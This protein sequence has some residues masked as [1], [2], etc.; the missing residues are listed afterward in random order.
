[1]AL[2]PARIVFFCYNLF[3]V[4]LSYGFLLHMQAAILAFCF[5]LLVGRLGP[6]LVA[7][8]AQAARL[9]SLVL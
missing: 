6:I 9:L 1:M 7:F 8:V 4:A 2:F 3:Y 5:H